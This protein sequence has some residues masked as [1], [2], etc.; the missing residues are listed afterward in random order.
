MSLYKRQDSPKWWV[1]IKVG[2]CLVQKSTGTTDKL[3]AQQ[4]HD[5]LKSQLWDQERLGVK[6]S[7]SWEEAV[8]RWLDETQHKATHRGGK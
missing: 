1:K 4:F 5:K 8:V 3:K 7:R 2:K 6:P